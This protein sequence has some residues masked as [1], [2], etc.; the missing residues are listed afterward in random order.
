MF[1]SYCVDDIFSHSGFVS[2]MNTTP[3]APRKGFYE[4]F[5]VGFCLA[6]L[7]LCACP[8][9]VP[10]LLAQPG[11]EE[12]KLRMAESYEQSGDIRSASRIYQ[13][14]YET[15]KAQQAYFDGVTRTLLALN[16]PASLL[17]LVD[18]QIV[19]APQNSLRS[20]EL[21][22]LKGDL[23]WKTGKT[24]QAEEAWKNA[25]ATAPAV[26]QAYV[27]IARAQAANRAFEL[28]IATLLQARTRLASAVLFSDDLS[29]FY[30]AVGN[31]TAGAQETLVFLKQTNN[32]NTAQGRISAYLISPKGIEQTRDV[33][34]KATTAEPNN[35]LLQR[36]YAW[37]LR[38][39]KDYNRALD[40]TQRLDN[41][42]NAQGRELLMFAEKA[43]QERYFDAAL[44]GY[45]LVIDKGRLNPNALSAFYGYARTMENRLEDAK[46]TGTT[47]SETE[48]NGI[49]TRY[50][51]VAADY[52]GTQ[53]AAE[54][55]YRIARITLDNLKKPDAA[56]QEFIKL[57]QLYRAFPIAARGSVDLGQL[58]VQQ[59]RMDKAAET[60]RTTLQ[61]FARMRSECDEA[62]FRLA[63][64]E[65]FSG[66]L[67]SADRRFAKLAANTNADIANDALERLALLE[68]KRTPDGE[69]AVK[70]FASAELLEKQEKLDEAIAAYTSLASTVKPNAPHA[71]IGEQALLKA[72]SIELRRKRYEVA[73]KLFAQLLEQFPEG[74]LGDFAMMYQADALA[75]QGRKDDAIQL[76]TQALA[77]FSRSTLLQQIR[78]KIRKLRGDA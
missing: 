41:M 2:F 53:Y 25:L 19:R 67:D 42:L 1:V 44:K 3:T 60:F 4:Y 57:V 28:A 22:A 58:Y 11:M 45:G 74:T 61:T 35:F 12:R 13:E 70:R 68:Q 51:A 39:M 78:L 73:G 38:E 52:P 49:I 47:F 17:P 7:F 55:Q 37:V 43:R 46:T 33:L 20:T 29:Q 6:A 77:R 65:Y 71:N 75:L 62:E 69:A 76:Y 66:N 9:F 72:G 32:L 18:E 24:T 15:N 56:E 50:R 30:G 16:Q 23:L 21:Q 14:L 5:V 63:E 59:N 48:L 34:E 27:L 26:Q 64:L 54:S 36:L 31:F 10:V 40:I 8:V